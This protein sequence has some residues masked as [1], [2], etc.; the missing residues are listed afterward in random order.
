[1]RMN[2]DENDMSPSSL[3]A[4]MD[5]SP[6]IPTQI[7]QDEAESSRVSCFSTPVVAPQKMQEN[8]ITPLN[9][10]VF[11]PSSNAIDYFANSSWG[12]QYSTLQGGLGFQFPSA[13]NPVQDP[14][15]RALL[16]NNGYRKEQEMVS[17]SQETAMSNE[18]SSAMSNLEM[19][20]KPFEGQDLACM[21]SY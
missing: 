18:N 3:P 19:G 21:W 9:N 11:A 14:S 17:V 1:M 5:P 16:G 7:K 13:S 4:L 2:P 15:F 10:Q 6:Y 20:K 12:Q 8:M